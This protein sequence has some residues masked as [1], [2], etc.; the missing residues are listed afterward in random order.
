M[1]QK[2]MQK[3]ARKCVKQML[4]Q[5]SRVIAGP[6][7]KNVY[8]DGPVLGIYYI[9]ILTNSLVP[10]QA[11]IQ[12]EVPHEVH[13]LLIRRACKNDDKRPAI[14]PHTLQKLPQS[15]PRAAIFIPDQNA[16]AIGEYELDPF[17]ATSGVEI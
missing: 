5:G 11:R 2:R 17:I 9:R 10:T 8:L 3:I 16:I 6:S 15:G 14:L 4:V 7:A 1:T 12:L 13:I